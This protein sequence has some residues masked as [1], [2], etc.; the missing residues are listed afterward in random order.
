[1]IPSSTAR[2]SAWWK[3]GVCVASGVSRRYTRPSETMYTGGCCASIVRICDGDVSVR[4]TVSSS[5]K[6]VCSGEREGWP[7]GKLR[8]SKL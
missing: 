5:R 8:A 3:V 6:S 2:P 4:R 7:S 1:M